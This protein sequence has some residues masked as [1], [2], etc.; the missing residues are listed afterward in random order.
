M[1]LT[2]IEYLEKTEELCKEIKKLYEIFHTYFDKKTRRKL[3]KT[4]RKFLKYQK[5]NKIYFKEELKIIENLKTEKE[6]TLRFFDHIENIEDEIENLRF[7]TRIQ[8]ALRKLA[9]NDPDKKPL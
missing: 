1:P 4:L 9:E 6:K 7:E 8:R 5:R 3:V 2:K